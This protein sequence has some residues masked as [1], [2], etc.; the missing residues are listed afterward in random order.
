MHIAGVI[1]GLP[2]LSQ[3]IFQVIKRFFGVISFVELSIQR[4][5]DADALFTGQGQNQLFLPSAQFNVYRYATFAGCFGQR[6]LPVMVQITIKR[7]MRTN[8]MQ[9][10]RHLIWPDAVLIFSG[11]FYRIGTKTD[12]FTFNHHVQ[13]IAIC[14]WLG[15]GNIKMIF[16]HFQYFTHR[17]ADKFRRIERANIAFTGI[18]KIIC[19]TTVESLFRRWN[20]EM[21]STT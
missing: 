17:Q 4:M 8:F 19:A 6:L 3:T 21:F 5:R 12:Y 11:F 7:M 20:K 1:D 16:R 9:I 14:Q 13:A 2:Q 10:R 15:D 18:H